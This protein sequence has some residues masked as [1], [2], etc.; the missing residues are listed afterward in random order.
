M[1]M[2]KGSYTNVDE[3]SAA[4]AAIRHDEIL[5][6]MH[7]LYEPSATKIQKMKKDTRR[8]RMRIHDNVRFV[9]PCPENMEFADKYMWH[10]KA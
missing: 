3:L 9:A 8:G 1:R 6:Q 5:L 4:T 7:V 10:S 2:M